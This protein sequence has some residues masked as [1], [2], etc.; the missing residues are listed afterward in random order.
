MSIGPCQLPAPPQATIPETGSYKVQGQSHLNWPIC[1]KRSL[2]PLTATGPWEC[3]ETILLDGCAKSCLHLSICSVNE[4]TWANTAELPWWR[5]W[6]FSSLTQHIKH[7][8]TYGPFWGDVIRQFKLI[9]IITYSK[10]SSSSLSLDV[11]RHK[12][13]AEHRES[14]T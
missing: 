8:I 7:R 13:K 14:L 4:V 3:P 12:E 10:I 2:S 9:V 11:L 6:S 1:W 5:V